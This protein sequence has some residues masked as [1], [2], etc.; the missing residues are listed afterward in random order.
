[1][2]NTIH[3]QLPKLHLI[4][5]TD[6]LRPAMQYVKIENGKAIATNAHSLLVTDLT[7]Y[8]DDKDFNIPDCYIHKDAWKQLCSPSLLSFD[9]A[10][11]VIELRFKKEEKLIKYKTPAEFEDKIGRYPNYEAVIPES[12]LAVAS[13]FKGFSLSTAVLTDTA[14]MFSDGHNIL[15]YP[16]SARKG[17]R[18]EIMKASYQNS[19]EVVGYGVIMQTTT[20]SDFNH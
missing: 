9:L 18:M 19:W 11:G 8:I 16:T 5:S 6:D 7:K 15:F 4:C 13:D 17:I 1:M 14:S 3:T 10:N 12:G 20:F 2:F